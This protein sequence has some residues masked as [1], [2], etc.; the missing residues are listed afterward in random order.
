[1]SL[2]VCVSVCVFMCTRIY[3]PHTHTYVHTH[4]YIQTYMHTCSHGRRAEIDAILESTDSD[5]NGLLSLEEFTSLILNLLNVGEIQQSLLDLSGLAMRGFEPDF[6]FPEHIRQLSLA[7]NCLSDL[8]VELTQL[9]HLSILNM[10]SND[11]TQISYACNQSSITS[12]SVRNNRIEILPK[13]VASM[14]QL[15]TLLLDNN[16]LGGVPCEIGGMP[17]LDNFSLE[18]NPLQMPLRRLL[19]EGT[20]YV[21][22]YLSLFLHAKQTGLL[23]LSN[24]GLATMPLEADLTN[25]TTCLL[26]HNL[27][28]QSPNSLAQ[29]LHIV[30][31]DLSNNGME[32]LDGSM[33]VG[34]TKLQVL[35]MAGNKLP[36]LC[37]R[38]GQMHNLRSLHL[39]HNKIQELP[40]TIS[41]LTALQV[42]DLSNNGLESMP[43]TIAGLTLL[44]DLILEH[45]N[46]SGLPRELGKMVGLN[47]LRCRGNN[48][49]RLPDCFETMN[50]RVID[51][52]HNPI[53]ALPYSLGSL[54]T[55]LEDIHVDR[56][57]HL[58][59]PP[60]VMIARGTHALLT[61]LN[62]QLDA[63]KT[64][65]L[66]LSYLHISAVTAPLLK[67]EHLCGGLRVLDVSNNMLQE[68]PRNIGGDLA[69]LETLIAQN[70]RLATLPV[71]AKQMKTLTY[72]DLSGNAFDKVPEMLAYTHQIRY[73]NLD[74]NRLTS[75]YG[76]MDLVTTGGFNDA[77]TNTKRQKER[78]VVQGMKGLRGL[79][80]TKVMDKVATR[81][82][83]RSRSKQVS[84]LF[85]LLQ[86]V[87]LHVAENAVRVLPGSVSQFSGLTTLDMHSNQLPDIPPDIGLCTRLTH[88]DL[89]H[90]NIMGLPPDIGK[91]GRVAYF[92]VSDNFI[93]A[94]PAQ[95]GNMTSLTELNFSNNEVVFVPVEI[96]GLET[97]LTRLHAAGNKIRDPPAAILEQGRDALFTYLRRVRN[98]RKSR[99]LV[100]MHVCVYACMYVCMVS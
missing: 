56:H 61:Y 75:V 19:Q 85:Q 36:G 72:L 82:Q 89:S 29:A 94:L 9:V 67:I 76:S 62:R 3:V 39:S 45:N 50:L 81:L 42:L 51:F 83:S 86:L 88:V 90:N 91:L 92:N 54:V 25:I 71:S 4:K 47:I 97:I 14:H 69:Y 41:S 74:R 77:I 80:Q 73:V 27:L 6:K 28:E 64:K 40:S 84:G 43:P 78:E 24:M 55:C 58:E 66:D 21:F 31:L 10:D 35:N 34:F 48:I 20:S 52:T 60:D 44:A 11:L 49:S 95:I 87:E 37:R 12:L 18:G 79:V 98:G 5:G 26:A 15:R 1:M 68:L 32:R 65:C 63:R 16:Q 96:E 33:M 30:H 70:N 7:D 13:W 2:C 59:D 53:A 8:P 100:C 23:D 99:E 38:I 57:L 93:G 17:N 22:A 46:L